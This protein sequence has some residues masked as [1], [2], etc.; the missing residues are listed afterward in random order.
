MEN[1][2]TK[3]TLCADDISANEFDSFLKEQFSEYDVAIEV[4][5][6]EKEGRGID[7]LI[8]LL[9]SK[10]MA[11]NLLASLLFKLVEFGFQKLNKTFGAK[12]VVVITLIDDTRIELPRTLSDIE[13]QQRILESVQAMNVKSIQFDS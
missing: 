3:I 1:N 10:D 13:I 9:F 6:A 11:V 8:S 2:S 7:E 12:P 5:P 4:V